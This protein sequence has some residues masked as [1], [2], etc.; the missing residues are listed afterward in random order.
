MKTSGAMNTGIFTVS[1][2]SFEMMKSI[3]LAEKLI[4]VSSVTTSKLGIL[5]FKV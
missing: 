3:S 2:G 1:I 4:I 5:F